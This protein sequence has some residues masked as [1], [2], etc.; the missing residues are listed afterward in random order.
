LLTTARCRRYGKR[1]RGGHHTARPALEVLGEA[2][3]R[4]D[5]YVEKLYRDVKAKDIVEG[6]GQIQRIVIARR[7]LGYPATT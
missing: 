1:R 4:Q 7:L 6:S 3:V 5:H 2:G